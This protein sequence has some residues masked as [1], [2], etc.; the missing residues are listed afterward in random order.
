VCVSGAHADKPAVKIEGP[1]DTAALG[2]KSNSAIAASHDP[3]APL[4][5]GAD[6]QGGRGRGRGSAETAMQRG[7]RREQRYGGRR[8]CAHPPARRIASDLKCGRRMDK[9]RNRSAGQGERLREGRALNQPRPSPLLRAPLT[10]P[11][12]PRRGTRR[13]YVRSFVDRREFC[14]DRLE[15]NKRVR[16]DPGRVDRC[17]AEGEGLQ[18]RLVP[19]K[20]RALNVSALLQPY[21]ARKNRLRPAP[22]R[23]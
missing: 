9:R 21:H 10:P 16:I 18:L 1:P 19:I 20:R 15:R 8:A 2:H 6:Q 3:R 11:A 17:D 4:R 12:L 23:I 14:A 5:H 22:G 7:A 13:S